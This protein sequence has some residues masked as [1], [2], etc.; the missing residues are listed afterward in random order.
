M[1]VCIHNLVG[2]YRCLCV[3][4]WSF[5]F[6]LLLLSTSLK[7]T[8]T[9]NNGD[10]VW[11]R[12]EKR[13]SSK[14]V[15]QTKRKWYEERAFMVIKWW[16][17]HQTTVTNIHRSRASH[18]VCTLVTHTVFSGCQNST[19]CQTIK[20]FFV[21]LL[22]LL[23]DLPLPARFLSIKCDATFDYKFREHSKL[24][25]QMGERQRERKRE[26]NSIWL[27]GMAFGGIA[28]QHRKLE[29]VERFNEQLL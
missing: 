28:P 22:M 23:L 1:F 14:I 21:A 4:A 9:Y 8:K 11:Q 3:C 2:Q 19:L 27:V 20:G 17:H 7:R 25:W 18:T 15:A 10:G 26:H 24:I 6:S 16:N 13:S 29:E 12:K 5:F